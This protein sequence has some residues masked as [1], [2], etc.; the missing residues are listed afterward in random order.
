MLTMEEFVTKFVNLQCYVPYLKE[1]KAKVYRFVGCLPP[2]YK[3]NI[4]F[5][6]PKT[7]DEAIRKAK[8]CS[9][10]F[11]QRSKLSRNWQHKKND[12]SGSM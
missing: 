10:L 12:K 5:E 2:T 4:E 8:L 9:H 7:M 11:K 3:E 1:E 6:I